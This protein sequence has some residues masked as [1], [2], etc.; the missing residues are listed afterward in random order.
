MKCA[1]RYRHTHEGLG[2]PVEA[3]RGTE[4]YEGSAGLEQV[5]SAEEASAV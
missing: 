1:V 5:Y 3:E 4:E 2:Q